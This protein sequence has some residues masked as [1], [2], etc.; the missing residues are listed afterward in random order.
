MTVDTGTTAGPVTAVERFTSIDRLRGVAI[1]G[2]LVMNIYGFAMPFAAYVN[3]LR[4]GG[5]ELYNLGTW[6]LT[7]VLFDQKFLSIFAM[8]FG[9]GIVLMSERAEARGARPARFYY[10]RQFWLVIIGAL[11]AYLIWLGDI[12]F[13]Y[14][15]VGMMAYPFRRRRPRTLI[16]VACV[17]LPIPLLLN[18]GNAW[19]TEQTMQ[20][21]ATIEAALAADEDIDEEQRQLLEQWQQQRTFM[22]PTDEDLAKDVETHRGDYPGIVVYRAP[23]VAMMQ[24]FMVV[25]FGIWRIGALMLIGMA[26]MK[27]RVFTA[28]RSPDF[29]L[30]V[31]LAGYV[32][33]L[34]L[35]IFSA[36]DL[37]AHGFDQLYAMRFGG[38]ANY[39]GSVLVALGHV[40]LVMWLTQT[41]A[42]RGLLDR[43]AAVGRMALTNY[44]AHSIILTT[45]FYG[46]GLGLYGSVP[47]AAQMLFVAAVVALQLWWSPL[48][49]ARYRFGPAEWLWRSLTYWQKQPMR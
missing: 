17:I 46:Y 36:A 25:F 27:L 16:I 45:V 2:I 13:A 21:V 47:R 41:G 38:I 6:F 18:F 39:F 40:G 37:Y 5:T 26:L 14:A 24:V 34:P 1:L 12:L 10:R 49:L 11:H 42:L 31:M 3:P 43:F 20:E 23:I 35:T 22:F 8:L 32:C 15:L 28:E 4:M 9:A 19:Q 29:Y 33:G 7:H 30:R 48:W 44:L